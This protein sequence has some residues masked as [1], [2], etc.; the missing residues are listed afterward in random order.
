VAELLHPGGQ[1][2]GPDLGGAGLEAGQSPAD[3]CL[4][5]DLPATTFARIAPRAAELGW[6]AHVREVRTDA[7]ETGANGRVDPNSADS[8]AQAERDVLG[9]TRS[10]SGLRT[11]RDTPPPR[12]E[13]QLAEDQWLRRLPDDSSG[14]LRRKFLIQHLTR[15][16]SAP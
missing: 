15:Q 3:L 14:L 16:G 7:K 12:T 2:V 5:L 1:G 10:R 6:L 4:A 13:Q 8:A 11:E 9:A